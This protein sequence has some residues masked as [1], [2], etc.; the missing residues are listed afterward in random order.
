MA[1]LP[2]AV[3]WFLGLGSITTLTSDSVA[4]LITSAQ[5]VGSA[6]KDDIY[7]RAASWLTRSQL[8]QGQVFYIDNGKRILLQVKGMLN[9]KNGIFEYIIDEVGNVCHQL[10]KA[11]GVIN[12]KPN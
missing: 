2:G 9:G 5:R 7:H 11:G 12:G 8:A 3:K 10:F 1:R 6:L 4:K